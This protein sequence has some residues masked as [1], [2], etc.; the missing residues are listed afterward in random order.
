MGRIAAR[1]ARVEPRLRARHFVR[2]LLADLPRKNCWTI[3]EWA[4]EA[5]P[6][7]MQHLVGRAKWD[8]DA[9]RDDVREYVVEHIR[10][11]APG[12]IPRRRPT[13]PPLPTR[14][15]SSSS[16]PSSTAWTR[17]SPHRPTRIPIGHVGQQQPAG[18]AL[19]EEASYVI[20]RDALTEHFPPRPR[21]TGCFGHGLAN[22]RE[23]HSPTAVNRSAV[24]SQA[25]P[26]NRPLSRTVTRWITLR[27]SR[28]VRRGGR[29]RSG[30][31]LGRGRR[32]AVR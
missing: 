11:C 2:G 28:L 6:D 5:S 21:G 29:S 7:G 3:A 8:A 4:G 9:V 18:P 17:N 15:S 27:G 16:K 10:A 25:H 31:R 12:W 1:F 13:T 23:L 26:L 24:T 30:R 19:G 32:G 22:Y 20:A 14:P